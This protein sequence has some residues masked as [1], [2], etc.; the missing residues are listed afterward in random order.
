MPGPAP[1]TE[2]P[3]RRS[4]WP[5]AVGGLLVGVVGLGLVLGGI[6]VAEDVLGGGGTREWCEGTQGYDSAHGPTERCVRE[7]DDDNLV[8][9][10]EHL[11]E[12]Y[13]AE[14]GGDRFEV[15]AWPLRGEDVEVDFDEDSVT[16]RDGHGVSATYPNAVFDDTR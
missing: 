2:A 9:S 5:A 10:D 16:V 3:P 4:V 13:R 15:H 12:L 1:G 7:R 11:I 8:A 6:G 14:T